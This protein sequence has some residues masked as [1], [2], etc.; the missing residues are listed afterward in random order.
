MVFDGVKFAAM[1]EAGLPKKKAKLVVL[2]DSSNLAGV[3]YVALKKKMAERLGVE[4]D[5]GTI[6]TL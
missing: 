5:S 6:I 1:I 2:L 4:F 3:K